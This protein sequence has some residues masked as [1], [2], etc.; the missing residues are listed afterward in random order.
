MPITP[1]IGLPSNRVFTDFL[2]YAG[3]VSTAAKLSL[4]HATGCNGVWLACDSA[5]AVELAIGDSAAQ[6][7][8]LAKG[9]SI[10]IP[11]IALEDIYIAGKAGTATFA[12]IVV[13]A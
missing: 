2:F 8:I 1:T 7:I 13:K 11:A 12:M 5:S 6:P 4:L 3:S 10:W 9:A